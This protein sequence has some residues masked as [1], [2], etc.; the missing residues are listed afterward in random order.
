[1]SEPAAARVVVPAALRQFTDGSA[2]VEVAVASGATVGDLL[3]AL[4]ELKPALVRRI[5]DEQGQL[6]R[7]VNLYV[8]GEDVR[9][10]GGNS[11]AVPAGA[12]VLVL[13]SVAGG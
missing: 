11:A 1:V 13:P 12:E 8:D 5:R 3:D 2:H 9:R 7:F 4:A 10:A 6:R